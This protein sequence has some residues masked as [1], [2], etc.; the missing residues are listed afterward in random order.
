MFNQQTLEYNSSEVQNISKQSNAEKKTC[1]LYLE[2]KHLSPQNGQGVE[3]SIA[4]VGFSV[5]MGRSITWGQP[6]WSCLPVW[7]AGV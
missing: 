6:W 4:D 5:G 7:L 3:T 2:D 1:L